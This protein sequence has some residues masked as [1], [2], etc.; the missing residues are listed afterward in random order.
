MER[1]IGAGQGNDNGFVIHSKS[2]VKKL[3]IAIYFFHIL[4]K[5]R[6]Y[7][8]DMDWRFTRINDHNDERGTQKRNG[9]NAR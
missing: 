3:D 4:S 1:N 6:H 8:Y 2:N 5:R 7:Y 9:D